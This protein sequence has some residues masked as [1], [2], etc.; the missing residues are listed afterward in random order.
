MY[1]GCNRIPNIQLNIFSFRITQ[2]I[3]NI[4]EY[5]ERDTMSSVVQ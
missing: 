1:Y 4:I 3:I 5:I 2:S